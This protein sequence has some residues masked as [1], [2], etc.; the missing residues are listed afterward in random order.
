M[1]KSKKAV[2]FGGGEIASGDG[3]S[4]LRASD[5]G[6]VVKRGRKKLTD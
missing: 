4:T 5:G 6:G 2:V 3:D 1:D